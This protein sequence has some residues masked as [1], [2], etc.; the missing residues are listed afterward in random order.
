MAEDTSL[1]TQFF[2]DS[3][4]ILSD[5]EE[6]VLQLEQHGADQ[7]QVHSLFRLFHT[8]KGNSNMVGEVQISSLTHALESEYD[9]VRNGKQELSPMLLQTTFEVIDLL[10]AVCQEGDSRDYTGPMNQIAQQLSQL[11]KSR[12]SGASKSAGAENSSGGPASQ[13]LSS[14]SSGQPAA[15]VQDTHAVEVGFSVWKPILRSFYTCQQVSEQLSEGNEELLD[16]LM[17]LGME[18]IELRSLTEDQNHPRLHMLA[19]TAMYLEKFCAT[20]AREQV[21]YNDISYELLY[22]L[23]DDFKRSMWQQLYLTRA[24]AYKKIATMEEMH[25]IE[26]EMGTE[27]QLWVIELAF[28]SSSSARSSDFFSRMVQIKRSVEVPL[29]YISPHSQYYRKASDLLDQALD[30]FTR[31]AGTIEDGVKTYILS[32]E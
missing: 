26:Q 14:D 13:V 22:V 27:D 2:Q 1:T 31:I 23:L 18:T 21:D 3:L 24:I 10:N 16:L 9:Q 5:A 25:R 11:G 32:E 20:L 19:K 8:L 12:N 29:V 6:I 30:G 28:A 17:D 15:V 7:E 4:D